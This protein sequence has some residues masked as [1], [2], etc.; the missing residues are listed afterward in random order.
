MLQVSLVAQEFDQSV[1][2]ALQICIQQ[3]QFDKADS[4]ITSFRGKE[5]PETS[6]FWLNLIH[7]D[8]GISK[9]R[10]SH[11]ANVYK[12]YMQSGIDA[13]IFLSHNI[14]KE[15]AS[16]SLDLWYFLFYWSDIFSNLDNNIIDSLSVFSNKYYNEYERKDP[17]M[18][19]LVQRKIYQYYFDKQEWGKCIRIMSQVENGISRDNSATE[20]TAYSR[21]DVGQAYM[22]MKDFNSA[23]EWFSSSYSAFSNISNK[24]DDET[25][26]CL[27]LL[28]SRIYFEHVRDIEKS[29]TFSL[30]AERVNKK[31]FGEGSKVYIASLD[32][33]S[34]SELNLGYNQKGTEHLKTIEVLLSN[35]SDMDN[36]EK[37]SY[38]DK[39]KMLY[40]RLNLNQ[41]QDKDKDILFQDTHV[42]E[43][44]L[45]YKATDAYVQGDIE[46]AIDHFSHLLK[47]YEENFRSVDF[48]NYIY[49]VGSL[50]N[51]LISEGSYSQ[52]DSLLERAIMITRDNNIDSPL[53]RGL[54]ESKAKLYFTIANIDMALYWYNQA[55]ELYN[56]TEV[57]SLQYGSLISNIAMCHL[58]NENF[59]LAK[60]LSDKAYEICSQFYGSNA[61]ETNDMLLLLNNLATIYTKMKDFSKGKEIYKEI[62][63]YSSSKQNERTKALALMNLSE[64]YLLENNYAEAEKNL[65]KV[66]EL[67]A[68]QYV[69][70]M[71]EIDL[72][73]LHC[74]THNEKA[75]QEIKHYSNAIKDEITNLFAHFSEIERENYWTQKSQSLVFLNNL[76]ALSFNTPETRIMAYDNALFT[77]NMLI[78]SGRLL[79]AIVKGSQQ[80]TQNAYSSMQ[81]L[82]SALSNKR[83]PKDSINN[84]I[85]KISILEKQ[86][87]SL[88]PDFGDKL[89]SQF[90][91]TT[92]IRG[93]LSDGEIA[94]EF[95]FLPQIKTPFEDSELQYGALILTKDNISPILIPL[96]SEF[97][98]EDIY[99]IETSTG[100]GFVEQ[101][102]NIKD[103]RL[104]NMVWAK[105]E[106]YIPTGSVVY[107]SPTGYIS[108]I[109]L[110]ALSDG[111]NR[112]MDKFM[113][114][115]V[116]TTAMIGEIKTANNV[117]IN[118]AVL[119]G[120]IN[121]YTDIDAMNENS[122]MYESYSPG[123]IWATRSANRSS[124]DLLPA[125]KEEMD[126]IEKQMK[127]KGV[128]VKAYS[129]DAANEESFKAMNT[130]APDIIHIATH[131]FYFSQ[132][133][134]ITSNFFGSM[135]SYTQKDYLLFYSGLLFAGAN[136]VWSGK[137]I[138]EGIE[139]GIMTAEEISR[140][141]L[142]GNKLT[143]LSA[144]CTGLGDIDNVDGVFG[145]Q[146]AFKKAGVGAILMSLW[147]VPDEETKLLMTTFYEHYLSNGNAPQS[148]KSAQKRLIEEGKSPFYWASFILLD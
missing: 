114:R 99:D 47:M 88:I 104:Y 33:L 42:N 115:E 56:A 84:Y 92:D 31:L 71:A 25:Y 75:I 69:K 127:E 141:N 62:V 118:N 19:Y 12:P 9:Y 90:K 50:S 147:K 43:N 11:N 132:E 89:K 27:L 95:V 82:K 136:N 17:E 38:Y 140:L 125:T 116:S 32:F 44:T 109:N 80:E 61:K 128:H 146:R 134:D 55:K 51:A 1:V 148:L 46:E 52:A 122:K 30:E 139:D 135:I 83:T 133:E 20:Q 8:V 117:C 85:N 74:V 86:I 4:I 66:L 45:M 54:Y 97:D 63:K 64:I 100:Q 78:N 111:K 123:N 94:I 102:Y 5:L 144:C 87:V 70:D 6:I 7:S 143:V 93:M 142:S 72:Y 91:N 68:A 53:K 15:N 108:K 107:Y 28:L 26:G 112:L 131:G 106:P 21:F 29:Y 137:S 101:L 81:L 145:L 79:R 18:Y 16:N 65:R 126:A 73:F 60:Q 39:L 57:Q 130:F 49:V 3:E 14:N 13:F 124:W 34:V 48:S 58:G 35:V 129:Q 96:C 121:Y 77:K 110:S 41:D 76:A 23:E 40:L 22:N 113:F 2:N 24:E 103:S 37:Q 119:Y 59:S 98:L 105:I 120:D 138:G 67:D 36:V 10:Q